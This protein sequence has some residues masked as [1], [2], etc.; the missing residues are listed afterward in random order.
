ML[1]IYIGVIVIS[2]NL[3]PIP[4]LDGGRLWIGLFQGVARREISQKVLVSMEMI[5][6][7]AILIIIIFIVI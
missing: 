2:F 6:Y 1:L 5:S 3:L 7:I 4:L